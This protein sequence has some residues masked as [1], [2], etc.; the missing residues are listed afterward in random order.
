MGKLI[1]PQFPILVLCDI[2]YANVL[3]YDRKNREALH[4]LT[5]VEVNAMAPT[6]KI[7]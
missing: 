6:D 7:I 5:L 3:G 2:L 1:S 4:D